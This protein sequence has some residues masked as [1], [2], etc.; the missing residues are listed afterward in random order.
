[1]L[2]N[3]RGTIEQI[4]PMYSALKHQGQRLYELARQGI[5]VARQPRR[6][7]I[8]RLALLDLASESLSLEVECSS[9]TY[10]RVLADDIGAELGCGAHLTALARTAVGPFMLDQ[11][12]TLN[13]F[14]AAVREGNWSTHLI[15]LT[16]G[17]ATFP[18]IVVTSASAQALVRGMPPT[19][20]QVLRLEGVFEVGQTVA[21]KGENGDLLA[22]G[23]ATRRVTE[24]AATPST[25][26][27]L[28]LR[29]VLRHHP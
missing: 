1:V 15:S 4:P 27:I 16:Q 14:D 29:R 19:A 20:A 21:I 7:W 13:G 3:F 2:A 17:M 24:L 18:A 8:S 25:T 12:L 11:A 22:V 26:T 28:Q 23:T 9:G 10:I 5:D 6:V